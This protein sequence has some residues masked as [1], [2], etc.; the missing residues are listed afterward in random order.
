MNSNSYP[1]VSITAH[2]LTYLK[3]K[4]FQNKLCA[5]KNPILTIGS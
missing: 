1:S 3:F 5:Q 2:I 4:T